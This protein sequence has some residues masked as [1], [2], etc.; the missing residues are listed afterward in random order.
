MAANEKG[1]SLVYEK[2]QRPADKLHQAFIDSPTHYTA[3]VTSQAWMAGSQISDASEYS[4]TVS[5]IE[6]R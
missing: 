2:E 1:V 6:R 5:R 3:T 4:G